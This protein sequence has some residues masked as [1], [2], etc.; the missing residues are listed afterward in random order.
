[1]KD[2]RAIVAELKKYDPALAA[3]PRWLVLNKIDLVPVA[4][5]ERVVGE[6]LRRL[7]WK[8]PYF[9]VSAISGEGTRGVAR[10]VADYLA[11]SR[12]N[13]PTGT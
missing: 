4:D 9:A 1:M 12:N 6:I 11:R 3:K 10:A 8:K 2:A 7:R 5:Q 13:G